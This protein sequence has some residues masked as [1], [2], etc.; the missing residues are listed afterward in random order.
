MSFF[1]RL[2]ERGTIRAARTV[3]KLVHCAC[4]LFSESVEPVFR[5]A[6][7]KRVIL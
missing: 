6:D 1:E 4:L 5:E 7:L 3:N 2:F